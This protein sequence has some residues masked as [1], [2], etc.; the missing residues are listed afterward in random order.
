MCA[1]CDMIRERDRKRDSK[2][3]EPKEYEVPVWFR[4]RAENDH[5]AWAKICQI[6]WELEEYDQLPPYVVEDAVEIGVP[7]ILHEEE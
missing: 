6:I 7:A 3:P 1:H 5:I 4:I 2:I